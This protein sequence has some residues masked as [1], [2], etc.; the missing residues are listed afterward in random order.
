MS[1]KSEE[2][3]GLKDSPNTKGLNGVFDKDYHKSGMT[4]PPPT[5]KEK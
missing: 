1:N 4:N 2:Q 5:K 3:K